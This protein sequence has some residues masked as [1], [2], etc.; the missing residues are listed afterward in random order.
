[1]D[2]TVKG[3][4]EIFTNHLPLSVTVILS[5]SGGSA[6]GGGGGGGGTGLRGTREGEAEEGGAG[7]GLGWVDGQVV[8]G[9]RDCGRG[10]WGKDGLGRDWDKR[11]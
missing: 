8:W 4:Y 10:C 3:S 6:G 11:S 7:E 9:R 1:M 2:V 5:R